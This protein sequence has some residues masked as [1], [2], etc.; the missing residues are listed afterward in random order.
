MLRTLKSIKSTTQAGKGVVRVGGA[1]RAGRDGTMLDGSWL[2]E[3]EIDN[4]EFDDGKFDDEIGEKGQK[5]FESKNLFKA[6]KLFKK[7][8]RLGFF[9]PK[10][11]LAFTKLRQAFVKALI[12]YHFDPERH[13]RFETNVSSYIISR[14]FSQLTSDYSG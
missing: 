14:I 2:N 11:R 9:T 13:I 1:S 4:G 12:F 3:S 8:L 6:K 10:A 5:I 7:M